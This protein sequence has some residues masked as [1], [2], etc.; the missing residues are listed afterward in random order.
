MTNFELKW[1]QLYLTPFDTFGFTLGFFFVAGRTDHGL[2]VPHL[3]FKKDFSFFFSQLCLSLYSMHKKMGVNF[4]R[5]ITLDFSFLIILH[6]FFLYISMFWN[7]I[8]IF[9]F[10]VVKLIILT[11]LSN[12]FFGNCLTYI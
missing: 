7:S 6:L 2:V 9:F 3:P 8:W 12:F 5:I 4:T 11:I 10:W 1:F